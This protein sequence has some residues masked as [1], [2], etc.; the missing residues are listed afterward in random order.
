[1][2]GSGYTDKLRLEALHCPI[3]AFCPL[4]F[5]CAKPF[6]GER[7]LL[8]NIVQVGYR[9]MLWTD[10]SARSQ[11]CVVRSGLLVSKSFS[12]DGSEMPDGL[13]SVGFVG[14]VPDNYVPY[15][16]SDFYFFMGMVPSQ[17]CVFDGDMVKS[18]INKLG[19]PA[20][21]MLLARLSI[22]QATA[23]Y[24]QKLTL[25]HQRARDKV[26]S[27]LL[28]LEAA[29]SRD[30][31]FDGTL[32]LAHD[33]IAF[34]AGTERATTSRELKMFAHEGLID[35]SYRCICVKPAL[36][37]RYGHFIEANLPFYEDDAS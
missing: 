6:D 2:R 33:D 20:V 26:A 8:P 13:F 30:P 4:A 15:V 21:P 34:L 5:M 25:A 23:A 1:M 12:N 9:E 3:R 17:V 35:L 24:G 29:L 27:V 28:R 32:P 16:A 18:Q 11:A 7:L 37:E 14:G 22:N 36:H 31:A 19:I 10:L